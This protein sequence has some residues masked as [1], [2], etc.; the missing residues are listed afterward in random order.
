MTKLETPVGA[1]GYRVD[2]NL[3][4][5]LVAGEGYDHILGSIS[6]PELGGGVRAAR[7]DIPSV[8]SDV[9]RENPSFVALENLQRPP[10]AGGPGIGEFTHAR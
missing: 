4:K 5:A 10:P 3:P 2:G 9:D 8:R 6:L 1:E 7:D